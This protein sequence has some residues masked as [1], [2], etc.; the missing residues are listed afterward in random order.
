MFWVI[1]IATLSF[2]LTRRYRPGKKPRRRA[3]AGCFLIAPFIIAA[4]FPSCGGEM[5][6]HRGRVPFS[7]MEKPPQSSS[8]Q[9]AMNLVMEHHESDG[10]LNE[11]ERALLRPGDV[12]A[13]HMSHGD[14]WKHLRKGKIQKLPYELFRYGHV[15]LVV[16]VSGDPGAEPRL[17]QVAMKQAVNTNDGLDYLSGKSWHIFRPPHG[18][19]DSDRLREFTEQVTVTASNPRKAYDYS[20]IVGLRNAPSHPESISEIGDKFSCATLVVAALHYSGFQ[21]NAIHRSG[22]CDIVTPYQVVKSKG[23]IVPE[24]Q[25]TRD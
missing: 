22:F 23:A 8:S 13:F 5:T 6:P 16:P 24:N 1:P 9:T 21:L 10:S 2:L 17:L 20:G 19:V 14:S 18:S 12:I 15:A 11:N 7:W 4:A 25:M 3:M